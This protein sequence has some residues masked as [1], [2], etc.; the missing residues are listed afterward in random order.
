MD[1]KERG[2]GPVGGQLGERLSL[3]AA[4]LFYVLFNLRYAAGRPLDSLT[5]TLWQLASSAPYAAGLTFLVV[6]FFQRMYGEKMDWERRFR[7]FFTIGIILGFFFALADYFQR[8]APAPLS[9]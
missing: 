2:S 9:G 1:S 6:S 8:T 7:L 5:A 4:G 3:I